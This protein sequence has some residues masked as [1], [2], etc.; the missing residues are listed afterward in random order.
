MTAKVLLVDDSSTMRKIIMRSLSAVGIS[1]VTEAGDGAEAFKLFSQAP[2]DLV[3]TDWNMPNRTGLD[4]TKDIRG[5]GSQAPIIMI[6]T[7][8]ERQRV[9]DAVSAGVSDYL[10][11]PFTADALREKLNKFVKA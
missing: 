4:L 2:F 8:A 7:E 9:V 5:G 3:L 1:D 6:T 11:K 10:I